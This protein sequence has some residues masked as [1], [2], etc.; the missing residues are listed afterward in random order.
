[1]GCAGC[2]AGPRLTNNE[3]H[4]VGTG[5]AYQVPSLVDVAARGPWMHDGRARS[6]RDAVM[7]GEGHGA[8]RH[9]DAERLSDLLRYLESL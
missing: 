3:N 2:H 4:D 9:L 1:V 7:L 8:A 6:L 5:G